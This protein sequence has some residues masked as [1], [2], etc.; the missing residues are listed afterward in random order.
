M[1]N[2]NIGLFLDGNHLFISYGEYT[3]YETDLLK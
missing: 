2:K 1:T 3:M